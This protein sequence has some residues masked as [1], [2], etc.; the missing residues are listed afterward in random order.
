MQ[1]VG[2]HFDEKTILKVAFAYEQAT[3][4]HKKKPRI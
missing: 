4:W 3:G 1:L 2:R